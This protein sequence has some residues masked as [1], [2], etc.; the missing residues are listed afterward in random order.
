ME[1][2]KKEFYSKLQVAGSIRFTVGEESDEF[3]S[4]NKPKLT[5]NEKFSHN[6]A[7]ILAKKKE[8]VAVSLTTYPNSCIINI[9]KNNNWLKEDYH[10]INKIKEYLIKISNYKCM[11]WEEALDKDETM[12]LA[13][14]IMAYCSERF[15]SRFNKLKG[16]IKDGKNSQYIKSFIKYASN[17]VN[18]NDSKEN[19]FII[20]K[21]CCYYYKKVS[22]VINITDIPKKFLKHLKKVGSYMRSLIK[23]TNC[24]CNEKF[25]VLFANIEL[26]IL[27]SIV[28]HQ[29]IYSWKHIIEEFISASMKYKDFKNACLGDK[30]KADK[31]ALIYGS[32][33]NLEYESIKNC[34]YL[35]AEM[36]ILN[37]IINQKKKTRVYIAVSKK[38]CYLCELCIKFAQKQGYN[39]LIS[40]M[41]KKIYNLWKLPSPTDVT[42]ISNFLTYAINELN[43]IIQEEVNNF[44]ESLLPEF[45]SDES[46][47]NSDE[48][49]V[50]DEEHNIF[51]E[52]K[53]QHYYFS[54]NILD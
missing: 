52:T 2:Q 21:V 15:K 10:Y 4:L 39:I 1:K 28:T 54:K 42:F 19:P 13:V 9:S 46:S 29:P 34:V 51:I 41:H 36:N 23:I 44:S 24:A 14:S 33:E 12:D 48:I 40:G 38:C 27:K 31:I 3:I 53:L 7:T 6:L 45:D 30:I 16:D 8:V 26:N 11:S 49:M 17:S 37:E 20:S 50:D 47:M 35:H 18:I 22:K 25:K 5:N 43:Q 32:V